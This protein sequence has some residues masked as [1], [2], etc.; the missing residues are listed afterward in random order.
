MPWNTSVDTFVWIFNVG[1]GSAAFVR[2]SLNQGMIIDMSCSSE[3]STSDFILNNLHK[4][5]DDYEGKRIAQAILT[6][7]HHDHI[8]DCGS[9]RDNQKLHPAL[10]TC[11][12]D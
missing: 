10:I 6:H 5:L 3:F 4:L 12:N 1:R 2:T 9:L 7:P 11:P 8:S